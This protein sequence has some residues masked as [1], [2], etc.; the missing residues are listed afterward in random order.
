VSG[1]YLSLSRGNAGE[2]GERH[3]ILLELGGIFWR[4]LRKRHKRSTNVAYRRRDASGWFAAR[5]RDAQF[6]KKWQMG[7]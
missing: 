3:V 4:R 2:W 1:L 6:M 7:I 5:A